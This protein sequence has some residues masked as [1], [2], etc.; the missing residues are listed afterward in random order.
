MAGALPALGTPPPAAAPALCY[1]IAPAAAFFPPSLTHRSCSHFALRMSPRESFG[2][3]ARWSAARPARR[4]SSSTPMP[5][6]VRLRIRIGLER[7]YHGAAVQPQLGA[8]VVNPQ[9]GELV[10]L[11]IGT[12]PPSARGDGPCTGPASTCTPSVSGTSAFLPLEPI[13]RHSL[14]RSLL[15]GLGAAHPTDD[16]LGERDQLGGLRDQ[17]EGRL[18]V[19]P[20]CSIA[21]NCGLAPASHLV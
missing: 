2:R 15:R 19:A 17:K 20:A 4:R 6:R 13:F 8:A 14:F 9:T 3:R 18:K 21:K 12:A 7:Q 10:G 16:L 5:S 1:G 11:I